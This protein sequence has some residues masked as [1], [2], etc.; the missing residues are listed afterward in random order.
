MKIERFYGKNTR[1]AMR[2]VKETLG[3]D[4]LILTNRNTPQGIELTA[5]LS[6]AG[7]DVTSASIGSTVEHHSE[8]HALK[9]EVSTLKTLIQ[10]QLG[11]LVWG[12]MKKNTPIQAEMMR[13]LLHD[14]FSETLA[15]RLTKSL[16]SDLS[17]QDSWKYVEHQLKES[18]R[19]LPEDNM[20]ESGIHVFLGGYGAGKTTS[21]I[22]VATRIILS[23]GATSV[24]ILTTDAKRIGAYEQIKIY[25]KILNVPVRLI[26][27]QEDFQE[28]L[29]MFHEARVILIDTPG[30][31]RL[32]F[33]KDSF[34]PIKKHLVL[35]A[36]LHYYSLLAQLEAFKEYG[37]HTC[38]L[39]RLDEAL[40]LG[41][42]LSALIEHQIPISY[43]CDG[44]KIP[45]DLRMM[46]SAELI[47]R[48][49]S[50]GDKGERCVSD[51]R[52]ARL[53]GGIA[54]DTTMDT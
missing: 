8:I 33:L 42:V 46:R 13:R 10:E 3:E 21:L 22:K 9:D 15:L 52:L 44:Q 6:M 35:A 34:M 39:T 37:I 27:S 31:S 48:A 17:L 14:G 30:M 7:L 20:I 24:V 2:L 38:V 5:T 18:L 29:Q 47:Q 12:K 36:H 19:I 53:L 45:E 23:Q 11:G 26:Q 32:D 41:E 43:V 16:P 51:A 28:A 54:F 49:F 1:E 25:G 4:A 40:S 50:L